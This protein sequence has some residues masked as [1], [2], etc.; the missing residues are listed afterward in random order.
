MVVA[1][2]TLP[3]RSRRQRRVATTAELVR[4]RELAVEAV[5]RNADSWSA[6]LWLERQLKFETSLR[7]VPA[8]VS[9]TDGAP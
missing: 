1:R 5:A 7:R 2:L 9:F 8:L 3:P 6:S 4:L